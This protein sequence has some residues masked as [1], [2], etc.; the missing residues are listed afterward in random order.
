MKCSLLWIPRSLHLMCQS[1]M[2]VCKT[3][4]TACSRPF[5]LRLC[6]ALKLRIAVWWSG[7]S[8]NSTFY[9][10]HG[11]RDLSCI[12]FFV[13]SSVVCDDWSGGSSSHV[14]TFYINPL[15]PELNPI[16]YLLA[17]LALQFLHVSRI[18]VKSLTFRRLMSYI[19]IY[20]APILDVSRSHTTT[21]HSG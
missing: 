1:L 14:Q 7:R 4:I 18:R 13:L 16:C 20:G 12:E 6:R 15:K 9:C 11:Q 2:C 10:V 3:R 17:L 19:Y 5:Q 21:Q 8:L